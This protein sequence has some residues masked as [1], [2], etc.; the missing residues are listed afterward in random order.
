MRI[1]FAAVVAGCIAVPAQVTEDVVKQDYLACNPERQFNKA[2]QLRT[3][4]NTRG[5]QEFTAGALLSR[6]CISLK[7]GTTVFTIGSAKTP[8]VIR[9]KP[10]GSFRT[11]FTSEMAFH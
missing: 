6:T 10:K 1:L 8:G 7:A 4:G 2:E 9:V 3:S 11:F 5:L